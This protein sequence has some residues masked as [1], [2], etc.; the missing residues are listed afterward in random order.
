MLARHFAIAT[1]GL[2]KDRATCGWF[3]VRAGNLSHF[4][5]NRSTPEAT[6]LGPY[7]TDAARWGRCRRPVRVLTAFPHHRTLSRVV[8][9]A[10]A[11]TDA[12]RLNYSDCCRL[13]TI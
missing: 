9:A 12:R 13:V 5:S 6:N 3:V 1:L 2:P 11:K 4:W 8:Q 10:R 7:P